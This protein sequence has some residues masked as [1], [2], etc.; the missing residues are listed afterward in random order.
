MKPRKRDRAKRQQIADILADRPS[1]EVAEFAAY[2]RS[3]RSVSTRGKSPPVWI[4]DI[5]AALNAPD[6]AKRIPLS[7]AAA[8]TSLDAGLSKYGDPLRALE[9]AER[10]TAAR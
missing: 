7:S 6:D 3:T 9:P 4:I 1:S 2:S 5:E 10:R 8:Q